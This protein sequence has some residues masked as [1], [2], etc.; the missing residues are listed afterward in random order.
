MLPTY[1]ES[2]DPKGELASSANSSLGESSSK[3]GLGPTELFSAFSASV[4]SE[5][6]K[7]AETAY[8]TYGRI[9][10]LRPY[11]DI[12]PNEVL[13]RVAASVDPRP[14]KSADLLFSDLYSPFMACLTLVAVLLFEMKLSDVYVQQGTLMSLAIITCFGYWIL[15][16]GA[17]K[18]AALYGK[19]TLTFV[20][21]LS[22]VGYAMCS[23][24]LVL[25]VCSILHQRASETIF[26]IFWT[27]ICG[28]AAIKLASTLW[29]FIP[30]EKERIVAS[31][32]S[33]VLHMGFVMY[34]HFAYHRLVEDLSDAIGD[35]VVDAKSNDS[36]HGKIPG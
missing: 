5:S 26:L 35:K 16:S 28:S 19:S 30:G 23:T 22:A 20:Q 29:A 9:D 13:Q 2:A 33:V 31:V 1:S 10:F 4:W 11:F 14:I 36:R 27:L 32:M 3:P 15:T 12:E 21:I 34:L 25:F 18:L 7:R 24:C 6:K 8:K 17:L